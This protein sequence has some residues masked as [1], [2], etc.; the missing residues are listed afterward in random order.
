MPDSFPSLPARL[1]LLAW[2]TTRRM[3]GRDIRLDHLVRAG[4]LVELAGRGLLIDVA[5]TATPRD[6]D[7]HSGDPVLDGLLELVRESWPRAWESWV[8]RYAGVTL[9]AVRAQLAAAGVLRA[10]GRRVLGL[11]GSVE[12]E[13]ERA[14][15]VETL[16]RQ[17]RR[18]LTGPVPVDE[19]PEQDAALA[20]LTAAAGLH[21]V[22]SPA[23]GDRHRERIE[24]LTERGSGAVPA[25]ETVV[26]G[27]RTTVSGPGAAATPTRARG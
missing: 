25:L 23:D 26:R 12:Y 7:A 24:A 9:D 22:V 20:A 15:T 10:G 3:P 21:T 19:V 8:T 17:V 11:F 16:Q 2:D 6:L 4:A 1:Y 18:T 13:L 5:G 14:Q 27:V